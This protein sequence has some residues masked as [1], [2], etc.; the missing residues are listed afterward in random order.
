ME[1]WIGIGL[2]RKYINRGSRFVTRGSKFVTSSVWVCFGVFLT[3]LV[4]MTENLPVT[5]ICHCLGH[6]LHCPC[7]ENLPGNEKLSTGRMRL[8]LMVH[9]QMA[10][11]YGKENLCE[12]KKATFDFYL[13]QTLWLYLGIWQARSMFI[14]LTSFISVALIFNYMHTISW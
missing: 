3:I 13:A 1:I 6:F 4:W 12:W 11:N 10:T 14:C 2:E 8:A 7:L 5:A 9:F